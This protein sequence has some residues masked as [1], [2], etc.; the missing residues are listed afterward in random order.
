MNQIRTERSFQILSIP[1]RT[2][3][4]LHIEEPDQKIYGVV[5]ARLTDLSFQLGGGGFEVP[6]KVE[7]EDLTS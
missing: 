6:P 3:S 2:T 1:S 4:H 7:A 5:T